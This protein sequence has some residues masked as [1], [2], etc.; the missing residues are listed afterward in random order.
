MQRSSPANAG[1]G[2]VYRTRSRLPVMAHSPPSEEPTSLRIP[3]TTSSSP[4]P[5]PPPALPAAMTPRA[6]S[7]FVRLSGSKNAAGSSSS[8]LG[9]G[10]PRMATVSWSATIWSSLKSR[11]ISSCSPSVVVASAAAA[12]AALA[13]SSKFAISS[14]V[15]PAKLLGSKTSVTLS[16]PSLAG[17]GVSLSRTDTKVVPKAGFTTSSRMT[18]SEPD[19]IGSSVGASVGSSVGGSVGS[20]VSDSTFNTTKA[21]SQLSLR[22]HAS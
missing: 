10:I 13:S 21:V 12:M 6:T 15:I 8:L 22:S 1:E 3:A 4:P 14:G 11:R 7:R 16:G 20:S 17:R 9:L 2:G 5:P 18:G 19:E